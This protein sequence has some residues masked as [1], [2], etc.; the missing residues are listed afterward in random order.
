MKNVPNKWLHGF[1]MFWLK[2]NGEFQM[3]I[4]M[5]IRGKTIINGK[6]F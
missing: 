3:D 4:K 2:N 1:G 5:V 6:E